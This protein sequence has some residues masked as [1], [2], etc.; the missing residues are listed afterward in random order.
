VVTPYYGFPQNGV[1][2]FLSAFPTIIISHY[3]G[4]AYGEMGA[5]MDWI[6]KARANSMS[7]S[8]TSTRYEAKYLIGRLDMC[9]FVLACLAYDIIDPGGRFREIKGRLIKF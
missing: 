3:M 5:G 2:Q 9:H 6:M 8:S 4:D 1:V 7:N